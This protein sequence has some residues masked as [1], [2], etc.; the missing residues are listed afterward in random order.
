[1]LCTGIVVAEDDVGLGRVV[2]GDAGEPVEGQP[3]ESMNYT[4]REEKGP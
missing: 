4:Y 2:G 1:M 3:I